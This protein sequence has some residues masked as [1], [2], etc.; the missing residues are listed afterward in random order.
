MQSVGAV[1]VQTILDAGRLGT[2]TLPQN[3][4]QRG[5]V[6]YQFISL[7]LLQRIQPVP[8]SLCLHVLRSTKKV[9]LSLA[10]IQ[11]DD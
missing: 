3:E 8:E 4:V 10:R 1:L 6:R 7:P 11:M 2:P 9:V 5:Y